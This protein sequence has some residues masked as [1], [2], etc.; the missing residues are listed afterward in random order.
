MGATAKFVEIKMLEGIETTAICDRCR[1]QL[2]SYWIYRID[3]IPK[4]EQLI[5]QIRPGGKFHVIDRRSTLTDC[6]KQS[7]VWEPAEEI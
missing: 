7:W 5:G 4:S 1:R 3:R 2:G 6:G